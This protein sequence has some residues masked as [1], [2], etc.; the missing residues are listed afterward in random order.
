MLDQA[1][2]AAFSLTKTQDEVMLRRFSD[3]KTLFAHKMHSNAPTAQVNYLERET[4]KEKERERERERE[5][6]ALQ[7]KSLRTCQGSATEPLLIIARQGHGIPAFTESCSGK[8][9]V[10]SLTIDWNDIVFKHA[11]HCQQARI[12][13]KRLLFGV[14]KTSTTNRT[15]LSNLHIVSNGMCY[16]S[17][18]RPVVS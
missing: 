14:A 16:N 4:E 13:C 8:F 3:Q 1:F 18:D 5:R 9:V 2:T 15:L 11:V 6:E 12:G 10:E 7:L 17:F